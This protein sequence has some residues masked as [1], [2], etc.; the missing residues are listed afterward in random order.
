MRYF[1]CFL[2][3]FSI[4]VSSTAQEKSHEINEITEAEWQLKSYDQDPDAGAVILCDIGTSR[5]EESGT[6]NLKLGFIRS[7]R[8][9]VLAKSGYG[10]GEVVIPYLREREEI[11]KITAA[12]YNMV[13]GESVKTVVEPETIFEEQFNEYISVKKFAFPDV[14][15]G[16]ILEYSYEI[17]RPYEG[18]IKDWEFQNDIPTLY[19]EFNVIN[20]PFIESYLVTQGIARFDVHNE[21]VLDAWKGYENGGVEQAKKKG[22]LFNRDLIHRTYGLKNIPAFGDESYM[23]SKDD[24]IV[25]MKF[26]IATP[27]EI[28]AKEIDDYANIWPTISKKMASKEE[29]G[30]FLKLGQKEAAE[31]IEEEFNF[32]GKSDSQKAREIIRFVKNKYRHNGRYGKYPTQS[33]SSFLLNEEGNTADINLWLITLLRSAGIEANPIALSTREHGKINIEFPYYRD[34]NYLVALVTV[35]GSQFLTDASEKYLPYNRIPPR[36]INGKGLVISSDRGGWVRL[37]NRIVSKDNT[38]ITIDPIPDEGTARVGLTIQSSVYNAYRMKSLLENDEEKIKENMIDRGFESIDKVKTFNHSDNAKPYI[39]AL[40]GDYE[41]ESIADKLIVTPFL[42]FPIRDNQL[43]QKERRYPIDFIYLSEVS[44]KSQIKIPEGYDLDALPE[45]VSIDDEI[46][47]IQLN[48]QESGEQI[49]VNGFY[50]FKKVIY[51]PED[52][53]QLK[54]YFNIIIDNFNQELILEKQ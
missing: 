6:F 35:D 8:I 47:K 53:Q 14:Q 36:C 21:K 44:L 19:S 23:T 1:V 31:T 12:T 33:V 15:I 27:S 22:L 24:F 7:K 40:K 38:L 50:A 28:E 9:K 20:L 54:N 51:Q 34:F 39:V 25:K 41:L 3:L 49:I 52:Y 5:L 43:R 48:Y 11:L 18:K 10:E 2:L 17:S 30:G 45:A 26:M 37:D 32:E 13:N 46:A 4:S 16:A 29:I 42:D